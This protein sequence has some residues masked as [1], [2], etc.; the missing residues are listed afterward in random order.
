MNSIRNQSALQ[1]EKAMTQQNHT[2][3]LLVEDD[4]GHARL[5]E[6]NL[7]RAEVTT[8]VVH[9]ADG[10]KALDFIFSGPEQA[11]NLIVL[12]DLNLPVC[13]G[14]TVLRQIRQHPQ[15]RTMPVIVLTTTGDT[16]EIKRCYDLGCNL[17]VTKPVDSDQFAKV[18][19]KLAALLS[20]FEMP[21]DE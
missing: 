7:R 18:I 20:I 2:T 9:V 15:T 16:A 3:I 5:I 11:G 19:G 8:P 21:R 10:Q 6:K 1:E 12:L 14:Y 13:D 17:Y 4:P